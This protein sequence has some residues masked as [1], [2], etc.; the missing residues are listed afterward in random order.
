MN[1]NVLNPLSFQIRPLQQRERTS[2]PC[3]LG[4]DGSRERMEL[5]HLPQ[6][7]PD[8]KTKDSHAQKASEEQKEKPTTR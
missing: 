6:E 3:F 2:V 7:Q 8:R 1:L 5:S 4:E